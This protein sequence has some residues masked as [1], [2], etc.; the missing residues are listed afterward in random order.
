MMQVIT[1]ERELELRE[2]QFKLLK[3]GS[4]FMLCGEPNQRRYLLA[5]WVGTDK[6]CSA[7]ELNATNR[8]KIARHEICDEV[9]LRFEQM[10][11]L[12]VL[13]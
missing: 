8:E 7:I 10:S 6:S 11:Y 3:T 4:L 5:R 2:E 1:A 12:G 9:L 13:A